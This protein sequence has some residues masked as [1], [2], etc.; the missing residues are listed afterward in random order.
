MGSR[1]NIASKPITKP[2]RAN[3]AV[4]PASSSSTSVPTHPYGTRTK[5]KA[6]EEAYAQT[7]PTLSQ[8]PLYDTFSLIQGLKEFSIAQHVSYQ[9]INASRQFSFNEHDSNSS[10]AFVHHL[11][12]RQ[13]L[14]L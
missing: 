7:L 4:Y 14:E 9:G 1:K 5:T 2:S 8:N 12:Q 11:L 6:L 10:S 13:V 3:P